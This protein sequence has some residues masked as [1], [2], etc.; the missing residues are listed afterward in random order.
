MRC[1]GTHCMAVANGIQGM[2][3]LSPSNTRVRKAGSLNTPN[4]PGALHLPG[5]ELPRASCK[6]HVDHYS[7][8]RPSED[9]R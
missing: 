5:P 9:D 3:L 1:Y 6:E 4:H 7:W 8:T 2:V